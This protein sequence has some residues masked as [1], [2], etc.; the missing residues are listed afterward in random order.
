MRVIGNG[1]SAL[2]L[3]RLRDAI[4]LMPAEAGMQVHRSWWIAT[5][6]IDTVK[7]D[8]RSMS[9]LLKDGTI[10]PVSRDNI[11]KV[12]AFEQ[13]GGCEALLRGLPLSLNPP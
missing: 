5:E 12:N 7:R 11:S 2:I 6:V 4:A 9:I 1:H 13:K 8:G 10:V 3:M